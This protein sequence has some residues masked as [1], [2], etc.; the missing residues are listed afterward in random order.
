MITE[1]HV[2]RA[3]ERYITFIRVQGPGG[4]ESDDDWLLR[5]LPAFDTFVEFAGIS[6]EAWAAL[7]ESVDEDG[8]GKTAA[9]LYAAGF[10]IGV[11]ARGEAEEDRGS[12]A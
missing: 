9:S 1:Q 8:A 12:N 2:D 11:L 5:Y 3:L 10:L 7:A 6:R 4:D